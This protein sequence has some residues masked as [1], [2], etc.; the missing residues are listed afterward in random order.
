[1]QTSLPSP[2]PVSPGAALVP[3]ASMKAVV[4]ASY[5]GPEVLAVGEL[6]LPTLAEDAVLVRVVVA[7][8]NKGDW[9]LITGTPYLVRAVYGFARP[10]RP[11]PGMAMAG[12]VAAVGA[13]VTG[14]AVGE[15]VFAEVNRGAFAEHCVVPAKDLAKL[16][17]GVDLEAAATI[18]VSG[19]TA[20]Q[21]LRDAGRL[22]AGQSVLVNGASG[23]V[24]CFAVQIAKA[25]GAEVTAVCSAGNAAL[26]RSLGADHVVDYAAEDFTRGE[27]RHDVIL[28]LVGNHGLA[29]MRRALTPKGRLLAA[30]GGADHPWVGPMLDILGGVVSNTWSAQP[31]VPVVNKV[32]PADLVAVAELVAQ[33]KVRAVIDR[34]HALGEVQEA[35]RYLGSG[36]VRGKIVVTV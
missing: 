10:S 35:V 14:F 1:M 28:D 29:A 6:P 34:R 30:A 9:H 23:G 16:P 33:G 22:Q 19:T 21:A 8:V 15:R 27:R 2:V 11:V 31:F 3:A 13:A 18:P 17:E 24:G 32:G 20:L 36:R 5:G 12:H 26:V 25:M 7:G 4:Q